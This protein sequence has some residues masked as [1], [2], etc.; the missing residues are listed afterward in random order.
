MKSMHIN[1]NIVKKF[2]IKVV[3][4][5]SVFL[6]GCNSDEPELKNIDN[7]DKVED[8]NSTDSSV[9][10]S[11]ENIAVAERSVQLDFTLLKAMNE[12]SKGNF[13]FSPLGVELMLGTAALGSENNIS[14]SIGSLFGCDNLDSL[15]DYQ[16]KTIKI[17]KNSDFFNA[18]LCNALYIPEEMNSVLFLKEMYPAYYN[19]ELS[20]WNS[21][22]V[23]VSSIVDIKCQWPYCSK[24]L[25][26]KNTDG[27]FHGANGE[28]QVEMINRMDD[29]MVVDDEEKDYFAIKVPLYIKKYGSVIFIMPKE[30]KDISE[31][32]AEFDFNDLSQLSYSKLINLFIPKFSLPDNETNV[33]PL[34]RNILDDEIFQFMFGN[35]ADS[36][37]FK[38][39]FQL[40]SSMVFDD[41]CIEAIDHDEYMGPMNSFPDPFNPPY[42]EK[43]ELNRPFIFLVTALDYPNCI[44]AGRVMDF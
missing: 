41:N 14:A 43:V 29:Y 18:C 40:K 10:L 28:Y 15:F 22:E 26:N 9:I 32:V 13:I 30:G 21:D 42:I 35:T 11:S 6:A 33:T 7:S 8:S 34:I 23:I 5:I 44:M 24:S 16:A 3:M 1:E 2:A 39:V 4:C 27:I 38:P 37:K 20:L 25:F 17:N 12:C 31:F 19:G 36:Y